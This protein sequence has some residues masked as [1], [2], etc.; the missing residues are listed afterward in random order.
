MLKTIITFIFLFTAPLYSVPPSPSIIKNVRETKWPS[1][2]SIIYTEPAGRNIVPNQIV[3][4][5]L[6]EKILV[7]IAEFSDSKLNDYTPA[8]VSY[9]ERYN[10]DYFSRLIFGTSGNTRSKKK[11]EYSDKHNSLNRYLKEVSYDQC[12]I[13]G[14]IVR[15][16]LDRKRSYYAQDS[17]IDVDN[18]N[19]TYYQIILDAAEKVQKNGFDLTSYDHDQDGY[20]DHIIVIAAAANQAAFKQSEDVKMNCIWPKRVLF[21]DSSL[22][23]KLDNRK[24]VGW[25]IVLTV[26]SPVGVAAHEFF[27]ELGAFDLGDP[28]WGGWDIKDDNDFP[29]AHWGLMGSFGAWNYKKGENPGEGPSHPLGFNKWKMGWMEPKLISRSGSITVKAIQ[30]NSQDS[31]FRINIPGT[32]TR[33][34]ILLENRFSS[35]PSIFYDKFFFPLMPLDAGLLITHVNEDI[36]HYYYGNYHLNNWG[37]PEYGQYA[38]QVLDTLP[39]INNLYDERKLNAAFSLED[40]QAELTPDCLYEYTSKSSNRTGSLI[41]ITKISSSGKVMKASVLITKTNL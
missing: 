12:G 5:S 33:E 20:I 1:P 6:K 14:S 16:T 11:T 17:S 35:F 22:V 28:D 38:V 39:F 21:T 19:T 7:I 15:I 36:G 24:K 10:N 30:K 25:G 34:Y 9:G 2:F 27:H 4:P 18:H 41:S 3:F 32:G 8:N 29:I 31:L 40:H 26:D 37:S 23:L 13:F